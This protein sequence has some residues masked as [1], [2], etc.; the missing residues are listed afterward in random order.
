MSNLPK[1]KKYNKSKNIME[2]PDCANGGDVYADA[3]GT[4][5]LPSGFGFLPN[6]TRFSIETIKMK[7][8]FGECM[9]CGSRIF[10]WVS[11]RAGRKYPK[12]IND[13]LRK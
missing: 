12:S 7:G 3:T 13:K 11:K 8:H 1:I 10:N 6:D 9:E 4:L 2:C 5:E